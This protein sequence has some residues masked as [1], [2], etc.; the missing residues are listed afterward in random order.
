MQNETTKVSACCKAEVRE[1][2]AGDES[3]T[4]CTSCE[5]ACDVAEVC[6]HCLGTGEVTTMERVYPGEPH[7][8]PIGT[9]PC[10][11]QKKNHDHDD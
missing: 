3:A 5:R 10:I 9:E 8:A 6:V 11:C 2:T 4:Q 7:M 1:V